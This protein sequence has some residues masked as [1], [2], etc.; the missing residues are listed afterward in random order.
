MTATSR[1]ARVRG[2]IRLLLL[3]LLMAGYAASAPAQQALLWFSHGRP[4]PQ[5]AQ[6]IEVLGNAASDGLSPQDYD[7]ARLREQLNLAAAGAGLPGDALARLDMALTASMQRYL[8]DLHSGRLDASQLHRYFK[9]PPP[10]YFNAPAYL[11]DAVAHD[12]LPEAVRLAAPR[13]AQYDSLRAALARYRGL[14]GHPAWQMPLA[15][16]PGKKLEA[17]QAYAGMDL[18]TRRLVALGDLP[19]QP[20]PSSPATQYYEGAVIDGVR[21]FQERHGL[22][23]DGVLGAATFKQLEVAPAQ[24]L[25]QIE[26]TLERLRWTPL[27]Q[28]PRMIVVN[29]PEF[30]LRAYEVRD[31]QPDVKVEM[32][33]IVGRA[34][35]T[36]TPIF[37]EDMRFIE[38]SPY[39]NVP[40]SITRGEI[41]PRLRRDPGYFE[42]QGFEF[43]TP[44]GQVLPGLSGENLDAA[45]RGQLRIRQ[46]PG[47]RN[48]LGDIKFIFPNDM[49][50]YLHHTPAPQ[51]FDRYRR[52]F[53]HG[54]IRVESP[55]ALAQFV[56]Y[57]EPQWTEERIRAAMAS[58]KSKTIRLDK[59]VPVLIAYNTV[60]AKSGKVYFFPD[61]YDHDAWLD[62]ALRQRPRAPAAAVASSRNGGIRASRG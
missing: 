10:D 54:C 18:L 23:P 29:I 34:L 45:Q 59:P 26:L 6:A 31:G 40:S 60:V 9:L 42:Q 1:I 43:V 52:D 50:I 24:R 44:Q 20:Q 61:L 21:A 25:R 56:L 19:P 28:A 33:I 4:T 3:A 41:I 27:T 49:N 47:R 46:R 22:L 32:R 16:L 38:F 5:A 58:G 8:V 62:K 53:S 7:A 35:N 17:G 39:W 15:P 55:V 37:Q 57:D 48:A 14:L 13:L 36:R 11:D 51:L 30:V 2:W 12:R